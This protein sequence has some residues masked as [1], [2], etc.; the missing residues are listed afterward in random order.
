[1]QVALVEPKNRP[2]N[3]FQSRASLVHKQQ[4]SGTY[5]VIIRKMNLRG[6]VRIEAKLSQAAKGMKSSLL[7]PG[8]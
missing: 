2:M 8:K 1:V 6:I 7:L 4:L 5:N 3:L